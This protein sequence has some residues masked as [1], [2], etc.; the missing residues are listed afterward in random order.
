MT[1]DEVIANY[2]AELT[3]MNDA[4]RI[5][6]L[7]DVVKADTE[8]RAGFVKL[9]TSTTR[10]Q[11]SRKTCPTSRRAA[12]RCSHWANCSDSSPYALSTKLESR[13]T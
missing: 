9:V 1:D 6:A 4:Q 8:Y 10:S 13:E 11:R 3:A 5:I 2:K 12:T 7:N